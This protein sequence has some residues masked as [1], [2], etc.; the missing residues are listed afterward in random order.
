VGREGGAQPRRGVVGRRP[1]RLGGVGVEDDQVPAV[2]EGDAEAV[3]LDLGGL[4]A[5][6]TRT[7]SPSTSTVSTSS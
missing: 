3:P 1:H 4:P 6:S 2:Q 7:A 5:A